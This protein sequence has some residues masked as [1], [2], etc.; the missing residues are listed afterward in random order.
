[1]ASKSEPGLITSPLYRVRTMSD[2]QYPDRQ[3]SPEDASIFE[4][5]DKTRT[6]TFMERDGFTR[7]NATQ[8]TESAT[9]KAVTGFRQVKFKSGTTVNVETAGTKVYTDDGTTRTDIVGSLTLTDNAENR[10][11]TTFLQDQIVATNG[12]DETWVYNGSGNATALGGVTWTTCGDIVSHRNLLVAMDTTESGTR[13]PTRLRWPDVTSLQKYSIDITTWPADNFYEVYPDGAEIIGGIDAFGRLLVLKSD[14]LYPMRFDSSTGFIEAV[15]V[16]NE[17]V[18]GIEFIARHSMIARPELAWAIARD[19]MY[20]IQPGE[21]GFTATNVVI[22]H[23]EEAWKNLA[24]D[25]LQYAV[26]WFR[27]KD[28]Q[29]RTLLSSSGNNSGHDEVWVYDWESG[30]VWIE[31]PTTSPNYA[32]SFLVSDIEYDA[33]G[34]TD[35][36]VN[37]ADN[38][39]DDN[40][41]PISFDLKMAPNDL[42]QTEARELSGK[43]KDIVNLITVYREQ[44][45]GQQTINLVIDIDQG[46]EDSVTENLT[47]GTTLAWDSGGLTWDSGLTWPGGKNGTAVTFVNRMAE[48]LAP[49]WRASDA[50]EHVGYRVQF[51]PTE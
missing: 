13:H 39:A 38:G 35:G 23:Q 15:M 28:K 49:R 10:T 47:L 50:Y 5:M 51:R 45:G 17:Q 12:T 42:S 43:Q 30:Q 26:S 41:T 34:T 27:A 6:G 22:P 44:S 3:L 14:G 8:I 21:N 11:R 37:Q 18:R 46:A 24:Q 32:A 19:G 31:K 2:V 36:Y 9:A 16:E 20:R 40:G 29:V 7:F 1:M 48:T 33:H 4:N 25:R